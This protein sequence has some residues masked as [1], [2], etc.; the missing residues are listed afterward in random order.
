MIEAI[1]TDIEG[2]TSSLSFVKDVLFPY[3]RERMEGF[4]CA[5][6][7]ESAVRK[8]LD[9]M[10]AAAGRPLTEAEVIAQLLQWIDED[11]KITP[12]KALQGMIW[13]AGYRQGDFTGHVYEDA[14]RNLRRW[15]EQGIRLYVFSSGSVQAQRLLFAYSDYGDLTPLFSGYFDTTIGAKRAAA[16]YEKIAAAIDIAPSH[17]L[18]LSDIKEELDAARAAGMRTAWL[19]RDAKP[20]PGAAHLQA[21]DFDAVHPESRD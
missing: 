19:M 11:K 1:V 20:D 5:H 9:D 7:E 8:L 10:R 13:E 4:V 12:L 3:A 14:V 6:G 16:A 2:T 17:I 18:F 21:R 15:K